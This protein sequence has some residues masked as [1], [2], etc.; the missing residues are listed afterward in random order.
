MRNALGVLSRLRLLHL[1]GLFAFGLAASP[2]SADLI[3]M[4]DIVPSTTIG[5]CVECLAGRVWL[6]TEINDGITAD[7]PPLF[8]GFA[9]ETGVLG[10]IHLDLVGTFNLD[11]FLL[12]NDINV[13]HEGVESF[14]LHFYDASNALISSS[15]ILFAP[16]SQ[17]AAGQYDFAT[18]FGVSSVDLEVLSHLASP[19]G[20]RIEIREVAFLGEAVV[21]EPS[22]LGLSALALAGL[23][24]AARRRK[25]R[26]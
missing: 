10:T 21:P 14:R 18:V 23:G 19:S 9:G 12:W 2:A 13:V 1:S 25:I 20:E 17:L 22:T 6:I 4:G 3:Q 26:S 15:G 16:V 8:N 5:P 11:S 7:T 24:A